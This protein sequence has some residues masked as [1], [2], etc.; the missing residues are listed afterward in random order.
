MSDTTPLM[1]K[2][3]TRRRLPNRRPNETIEVEI[4]NQAYSVTLGYY[5]DDAQ[6]GEIFIEGAKTGSQLDGIL[7]DAAILA[8]R[9][10]QAGIPAAEIARS[11]SRLPT[12]PF[13]PA[14]EPASPIG[15]ALDLAA[16]TNIVPPAG[17]FKPAKRDHGHGAVC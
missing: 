3:D 2:H 13:T 4:E 17:D 10:L 14:T 5:P 7:A 1:P 6:V 8:S 9:C 15:A 12:S 11:M 16:A